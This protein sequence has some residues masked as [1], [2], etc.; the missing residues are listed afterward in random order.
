MVLVFTVPSSIAL[1]ILAEPV[2]AVLFIRGAFT[3]TDA[4]ETAYALQMYSISLWAIGYVRILNQALYSM[5]EA[6]TVVNIGWIALVV[7][8]VLS[9]LLMIFMRH[10]G[11][12]LASSLSVLFQL[13]V[14]HF[15]LV[16]KQIRFNRSLY[17]DCL[18]ILA[19]SSLMGIVLYLFILN[20]FWLNGLNMNSL[21]MLS[22]CIIAGT[23]TYFG[24]LYF[25]GIRLAKI[26]SQ[27]KAY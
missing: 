24:V 2:T 16:K 14:F 11:I 10:A 25:S 13:I 3:I 6:K 23:A 7:N 4:K 17:K 21:I 19:A 8:V 20:N 9:L 12:A 18:K 26:F 5:Q 22:A 1:I 15:V 27:R